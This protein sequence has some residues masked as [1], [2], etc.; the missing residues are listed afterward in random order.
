MSPGQLAQ[1]ACIL[2]ATARKP[3]NVHRYQ[4]F[5]DLT[6]LD[7]LVSAAAIAPVFD[8]APGQR[9]GTTILE[10]IR[11]TRQAVSSN[12]NL[13]IVLLL[14]PMASVPA[15]E[16]L[17]RSLLPI[18]D[19]LDMEDATLVFEAIRL[20]QPGGLGRVE[21]QDVSGAPTLPLGE[22]MALAAHHDHIAR[23]Y[24]TGF[25]DIFEHGVPALQHYLEHDGKLEAA[26]IGAH[27][28]LLARFPDSLIARKCGAAEAAAASRR[29][30]QVLDE[31]WPN[32][33]VGRRAIADFDAWLR[34]DGNRRNPGTTA[35]LVTASL[36]AALRQGI[37]P[38]PVRW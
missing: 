9:V 13:G 17:Q 32:T 15:A 20:A 23:Q 31:G 3:G 36:F 2:E 38:V 30:A 26:I 35:D 33:D 21:D 8:R 19:Q 1:L 37:I 18:L 14:A 22:I 7:F 5:V 27:L 6:Y 10:A 29:A 12:T 28:R 25:R 11:A 24:D 34:A 4:D 16:P